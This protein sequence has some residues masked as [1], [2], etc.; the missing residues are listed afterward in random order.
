MLDLGG[1]IKDFDCHGSVLLKRLELTGDPPRAKAT[2]KA[3]RH[4]GT[5]H[6]SLTDFN[7]CYSVFCDCLRIRFCWPSTAPGG[8]R[9]SGLS[10]L[11]RSAK[12]RLTAAIPWI[13]DDSA[14]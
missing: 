13:I 14:L 2:P 3:R 9:R 11:E 12:A 1:K 8:R 6:I 4:G 10:R 5:Y 7:I